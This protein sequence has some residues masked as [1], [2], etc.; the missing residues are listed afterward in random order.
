MDHEGFCK[1]D[2]KLKEWDDALAL[3]NEL[4][5]L[6]KN[7]VFRGQRKDWDL[8]SSLQRARVSA[9][10]RY[11]DCL[12]PERR[13]ITHFRDN[14]HLVDPL[15]FHD[16]GNFEWAARQQHYG[17]PSRLLDFSRSFWVGM[18]FALELSSSGSSEEPVVLAVQGA[19]LYESVKKQLQKKGLWSEVEEELRK[20]GNEFD[21]RYYSD[22]MRATRHVCGLSIWGEAS[23]A[24]PDRWQLELALY[25]E[26]GRTDR[27]IVAQSGAFICPLKADSK[28]EDCLFGSFR[29]LK[30]LDGPPREYKPGSSLLKDCDGLEPVIVKV[31]LPKCCFKE[32]LDILAGMNITRATLFPGMDGLARSLYTHLTR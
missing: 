7:W 27:R 26:S 29:D 6:E 19:S 12:D 24:R 2:L 3:A 1:L 28:F 17:G 5:H 20:C 15:L 18:F 10:F 13:V 16:V 32:G 4:S 14:A 31:F 22:R 30:L 25:A 8:A 11:T 9:G 21:D 23:Q